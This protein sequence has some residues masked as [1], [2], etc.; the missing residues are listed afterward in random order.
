[1]KKTK[2]TIIDAGIL[3]VLLAIIVIGINIL[4]GVVGKEETKAVYYTVLATDVNEG[5]SELIKEGDEVAISFSEEAYATVLGASEVPHKEYR[6]NEGKGMYFSHIVEGKSDV[7]ILLKCD[8]V[9]TDTEM[10][11]GNVAIRVGDLMPVCGKGYTISGYIVEAEE[12]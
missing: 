2:F 1:M 10:K 11:N 4:G 6:L 3:V 8:A 9:I 12:R 7:T 5:Y